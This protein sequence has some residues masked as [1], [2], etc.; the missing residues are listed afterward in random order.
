MPAKPPASLPHEAEVAKSP[1]K[2]VSAAER[3]EQLIA[4]GIPVLRTPEGGYPTREM[5]DPSDY[6]C[7]LSKA[8]RNAWIDAPRNRRAI[9]HTAGVLTTQEDVANKKKVLQ[10]SLQ[11]ITTEEHIQIGDAALLDADARGTGHTM[12]WPITNLS[13]DAARILAEGKAW[14][15]PW[16]RFYV[17][18]DHEKI[19]SFVARLRG[20]CH[21]YNDVVEDDVRGVLLQPKLLNLKG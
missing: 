21:N 5:G 7:G 12:A 4:L 13:E 2:G 11:L 3:I 18:T 19:P 17:E 14:S 20:F 9:V 16:I 8:Q 10:G 6:L 1:L 15:M